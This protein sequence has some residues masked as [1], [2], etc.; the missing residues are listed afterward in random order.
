MEEL[1][2]R[3]EYLREQRDKIIALKRQNR[4]KL[5]QE[6]LNQMESENVSYSVSDT[7]ANRRPNSAYLA[8]HLLKNPTEFPKLLTESI[9]E[10]ANNTPSTNKT[11]DKALALRKSL[12]KRLKDEVVDKN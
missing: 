6:N 10:P 2:S 1:N 7:E 9:N 8:Q 3:Q 12:A 5:L 11:N 4:A